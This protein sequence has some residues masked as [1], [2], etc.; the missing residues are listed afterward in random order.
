MKNIKELMHNISQ[1][2]VDCDKAA[3]EKYYSKSIQ[4]NYY[5]KKVNYQDME[6]RLEY[7]RENQS[8]R[9]LEIIDLICQDNK[10]A[11]RFHY[12]AVDRNDGVFNGELAG[13]YE[14]DHQQQI[15]KAWAFANQP[16]DYHD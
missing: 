10:I 4:A 12:Q 16:I 9:Q 13:F 2:W 14:F 3:F 7:M 5:G 6:Q 11:I 8:E 15:I 1:V